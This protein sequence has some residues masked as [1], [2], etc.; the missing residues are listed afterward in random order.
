MLLS[1]VLPPGLVAA[2]DL[3]FLPVLGAKILTQLLRRP[4]PQNIMFLG[5]LA[6]I[7]LANL[8]VHL[9]WIGLGWGDAFTGLRA[10]LLATAAMIAVLGGRVIPAFTRNAMQR[11]GIEAGL[12]R[13][14]PRLAAFAIAAAIAAALAVLFGLPDAAAGGILLLAGALEAARLA[15]WRGRWTLGQPILWTLHLSFALLALGHGLMGA[16]AFGLGNDIAALH[17]MGI[18]AVGG[19]TLAVMSRA[20]LGHSGR[21]LVAPAALAAAYA[22]LPVATALRW[23]AS[24]FPGTHF[25]AVTGAGLVWTLAFT[26]FL[27]A[28]WPAFRGGRTALDAE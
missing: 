7:W 12:P 20:T 5:L 27:I 13:Q 4:K 16:A 17:V 23:I 8:R 28:L 10:G 25:A 24:G 15:L 14:A 19:M 21:P 6:M 1:G 18:G 3:A 2:A 9:D 26:L 11:A 22:L